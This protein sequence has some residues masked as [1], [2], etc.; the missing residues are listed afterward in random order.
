M[1]TALAHVNVVQ[2]SAG[3]CLRA[4]EPENTCAAQPHTSRGGTRLCVSLTRTDLEISLCVDV[5]DV[6]HVERTVWMPSCSPERS[7]AD[8]MQMH[9]TGHIA[10]PP[11]D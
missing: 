6:T 2:L 7:R 4:S 1:E 10:F 5:T 3:L 11:F 8:T 9:A